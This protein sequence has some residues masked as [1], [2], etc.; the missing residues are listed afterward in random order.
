MDDDTYIHRLNEQELR[1]ELVA[2]RAQVDALT[3]EVNKYR[4]RIVGH[5]GARDFTGGRI[6]ADIRLWELVADIPWGKPIKGDG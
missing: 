3:T 2:L 4:S 6:E 1:N 5:R